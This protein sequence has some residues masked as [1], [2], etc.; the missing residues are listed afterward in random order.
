VVLA[1]GV[2][3]EGEVL[4]EGVPQEVAS[5]AAAVEAGDTER[6]NF[7]FDLFP[8]SFS[9]T[10]SHPFKGLRTFFRVVKGAAFWT[11][12]DLIFGLSCTP[13]KKGR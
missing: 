10:P 12:N 2:G 11:S 7:I 13:E 5:G 9:L 1:A 3:E 8:C 6:K 4:E